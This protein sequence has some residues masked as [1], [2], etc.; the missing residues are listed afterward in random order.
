[1]SEKLLSR[2]EVAHLL[3]VSPRTVSRLRTRGLLPAVRVLSALRFRA[4]DVRALLHSQREG[5]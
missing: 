2:A 1:M 4:E 3:S 5:R